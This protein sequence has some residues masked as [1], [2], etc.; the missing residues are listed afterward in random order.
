MGYINVEPN[1]ATMKNICQIRS[2]SGKKIV[3][4]NA[5]FKNPIN[6]FAL[7]WQLQIDG[8]PFEGLR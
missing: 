3:K 1:D 6:T 5:C 8:N 4:D 2:G 7:T